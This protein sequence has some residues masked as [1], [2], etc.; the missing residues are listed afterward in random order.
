MTPQGFTRKWGGAGL[1]PARL[2]PLMVR[3]YRASR[4]STSL[5][6]SLERNAGVLSPRPPGSLL[7]KGGSQNL[8]LFFI[9]IFPLA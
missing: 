6:S 4:S 7:K 3:G 1:A 9:K 5:A 8:F 2:R